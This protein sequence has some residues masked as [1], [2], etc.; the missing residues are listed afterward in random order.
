MYRFIH[1]KILPETKYFKKL[2]SECNFNATALPLIIQA[3]LTI[4]V[5]LHI[6]SPGKK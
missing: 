2:C 3:S 1:I 5:L 6:A 4:K